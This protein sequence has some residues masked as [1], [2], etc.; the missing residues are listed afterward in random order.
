MVCFHM[1]IAAANVSSSLL[2]SLIV[3]KHIKMRTYYE[4]FIFSSFH[5]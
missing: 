1:V 3:P 5:Y 4:V 2:F